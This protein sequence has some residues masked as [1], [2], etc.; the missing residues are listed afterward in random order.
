MNKKFIYFIKELTHAIESQTLSTKEWHTKEPD[1]IEEQENTLLQLVLT[2]HLMN[3][4]LW[5]TED[6]ARRKDVDAS[7]IA[8]CKY[9][10]DKY[11]QQRNDYMEQIDMYCTDVLMSIV[12]ECEE[13]KRI[14]NSETIG[15]IVD[16]LSI[17]ALKIYHM[18][19]ESE[20]TSASEE[21]RESC[22][23]K[24]Q[25]LE[26]QRKQLIQS[27]LYLLKEYQ[28]GIKYPFIYFQHKMYNNPNLNP[29]LYSNEKK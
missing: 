12:L 18:K 2:Q 1:M 23:I 14:Y 16:R 9:T 20:R 24:L 10:I 28:E 4:K 13:S 15:M 11:N 5:H 27:L 26:K 25:S 21:H 17:L 3:Y 29:Q 7:V 22:A 6:I 19:E 8:N